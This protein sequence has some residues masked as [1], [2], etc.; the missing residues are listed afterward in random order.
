MLT[1]TCPLPQAA[2]M[3]RNN[4]ANSLCSTTPIV[5][6]AKKK[7]TYP[8]SK[9]S[10]PHMRFWVSLVR[11][12]DTTEID[13]KLGCIPQV[14]A[15]A[16]VVAL[17]AIHTRQLRHTLHH[18]EGHSLV[19]ISDRRLL[20]RIVSQISHVQHPRQNALILRPSVRMRSRRGRT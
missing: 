11:R 16:P 8:N 1:S 9:R 13:V 12:E 20:A 5:T 10:K 2:K 18:P 19:H 4:T 7:S 14:A 6:R 15:A 3:S 17:E